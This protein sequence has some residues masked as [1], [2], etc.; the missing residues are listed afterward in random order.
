MA[1]PL[2]IQF[3]GGLY[4]VTARG[5]GRQPLFADDIDRE[6]FLTV[7]ARRLQPGLQPP[8]RAPG[9]PVDSRP[10][11]GD[12]GVL[13][14]VREQIGGATSVLEVP[15]TQRF[16][17]RPSLAALFASVTSRDNRDACCVLAVREH[18]YTMRAIAQFLGVH[19]ATVSRALA[20]GEARRLRSEMLDCKT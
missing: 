11:V 5:N 8:A 15:R 19:Y 18:G 10:F 16:A 7:L 20:Q 4:H 13:V 17:L 9:E 6:R 3:P 14:P 2:R 12:A 1:R